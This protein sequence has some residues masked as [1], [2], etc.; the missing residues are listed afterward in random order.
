M[1]FRFIP[2]LPYIVNGLVSLTLLL[3]TLAFLVLHKSKESKLSI[4]DKLNYNLCV[5]YIIL[6][7]LTLIPYQFIITNNDKAVRQIGYSFLY[8]L[9]GITISIYSF[10]F[11]FFHLALNEGNGRVLYRFIFYWISGLVI[12]IFGFF[13]GNLKLSNYVMIPFALLIYINMGRIPVME[14]I[15]LIKVC[16]AY[17]Q[18]EATNQEEEMIRKINNRKIICFGIMQIIVFVINW[19]CLPAIYFSLKGEK[20]MVA[21]LLVFYFYTIFTMTLN[22]IFLIRFIYDEESYEALKKICFCCNKK[23][24]Y[25]NLLIETDLFNK[26]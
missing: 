11:Y 14:T 8:W 4:R 23:N 6:S 1:V 15:A 16:K 19:V 26:N 24:K 12:P 25:N 5:A 10:Y 9:T 22:I 3:I 20:I 2:Y 13:Y 21:F 17:K 7:L 18:Y